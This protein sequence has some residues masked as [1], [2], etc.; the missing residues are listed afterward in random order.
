MKLTYETLVAEAPLWMGV[1]DPDGICHSLSAA[2]R[3]GLGIDSNADLALPVAELLAA[4]E[5]PVRLA[6]AEAVGVDNRG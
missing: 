2:W 6:V 3:T 5:L 1:I 4:T